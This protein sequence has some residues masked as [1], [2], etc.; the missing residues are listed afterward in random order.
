MT[1]GQTTD[2]RWSEKLN[3]AFSSGELKR[4]LLLEPKIIKCVYIYITNP[5]INKPTLTFLT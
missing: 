4:T 1:D 3:T 5:K 2:N